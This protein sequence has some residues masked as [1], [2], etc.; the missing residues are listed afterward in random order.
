M[1]QLDRH[2]I[3]LTKYKD[4]RRDLHNTHTGIIA[5]RWYVCE[6]K[7]WSAY[8]NE[9]KHKAR[10]NEWVRKLEKLNVSSKF[11]KR[12]QARIE[13]L[14]VKNAACS[15]G[16]NNN[17]KNG[18]SWKIKIIR[19]NPYYSLETECANQ[20]SDKCWRRRRDIKERKQFGNRNMQQCYSG[21][22][23][24]ENADVLDKVNDIVEDDLAYIT[25]RVANI[26]FPVYLAA[27]SYTQC[28]FLILRT[29]TINPLTN[30]PR[31]FGEI[32]ADQVIDIPGNRKNNIVTFLLQILFSSALQ[33]AM[34]ITK[35]NKRKLRSKV[36]I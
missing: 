12:T 6:I 7:G 4:H 35:K 24:I 8:W 34:M 30:E 1:G 10:Y 2:I 23:L 32:D 19:P 14:R 13:T 18:S 5:K 3:S 22:I 26:I 28:I 21:K 31:G 27:M 9:T 17:K 36:G 20:C 15:S 16:M 25:T 33:L 29:G 11:M